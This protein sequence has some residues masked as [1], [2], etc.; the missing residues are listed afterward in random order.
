MTNEELKEKKDELGAKYCWVDKRF[1]DNSR[2]LFLYSDNQKDAL[3]KLLDLNGSI[4][5]TVFQRVCNDDKEG[6]YSVEDIENT[7]NGYLDDKD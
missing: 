2:H 1:S 4:Y 3:A 5:D 6:K 7:Y